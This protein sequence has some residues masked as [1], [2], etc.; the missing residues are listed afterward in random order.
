MPRLSVLF[1]SGL[2]LSLIWLA[3][4]SGLGE[5]AAAS[6][7]ASAPGAASE[8]VQMATQIPTRPAFEAMQTEQ[9]SAVSAHQWQSWLQQSQQAVAAIGGWPDGSTKLKELGSNLELLNQEMAKQLEASQKNQDLSWLLFRLSRLNPQLR[10][11]ETERAELGQPPADLSRLLLRLFTV[12]A[13]PDTVAPT[14]PAHEASCPLWG[15]LAQALTVLRQDGEAQKGRRSALAKRSL[16][17]FEAPDLTAQIQ[18]QAQGCSAAIES[19]RAVDTLAR[20]LARQ[21]WDPLFVR[22][23][24]GPEEAARAPAPRKLAV[25]SPAWTPVPLATGLMCALLLIWAT[26]T[27]LARLGER[28][29]DLHLSNQRLH[30]EI[31]RLRARLEQQ[32]QTIAPSAPMLALE[33]QAQIQNEALPDIEAAAAPQSPCGELPALAP[34]GD[35]AAA[36]PAQAQRLWRMAGEQLRNAQLALLHGEH[37]DEIAQQLRQ[38]E[39][40]LEPHSGAAERADP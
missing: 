11:Y 33:A 4:I 22:P 5:R 40:L 7:A 28:S 36:Q 21:P 3:A 34:A 13:V 14:W 24:A 35:A 26:G 37:P 39:R 17:A 27:R 18:A 31:D 6:A 20:A 2:L 10:L 16:S 19:R 12:Y 8:P 15:E 9:G 1:W 30:D 32:S 38:I 23:A 29:Q 25:L